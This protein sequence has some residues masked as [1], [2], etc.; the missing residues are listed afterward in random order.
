MYWR[1]KLEE[2]PNIDSLDH[3]DGRFILHKHHDHDGPHLD[4][5]I[6]MDGYLMGWRIDG[7]SLEGRPWAT[8]KAPHAL[9]WLECDAD[10]ECVDAGVYMLQ[11]R[12]GGDTRTLLLK[13]HGGVKEL[14]A[15][16]VPGL[17]ALVARD[18][19]N[20]LRENNVQPSDSPQLVRD[21]LA[22]RR[23]AVERL[24]GLGR[25]LDGTA[26]D[27]S[28]WRALLAGLSLDE[29]HAQ[30]RAYEVRFDQKYPPSSVS[31]PEGLQEEPARTG[32]ALSIA[33]E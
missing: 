25:E 12:P 11:N 17:P 19:V 4:L 18:L 23:R 2:T 13:G 21:G 26:F 9:R 22:A 33:R 16:R 3:I 14:I 20:T 24:C 32:A 27:A 10:A 7:V 8:E 5:R 28:S 1:L 29:I 15:E 6:E 31:R 30:L